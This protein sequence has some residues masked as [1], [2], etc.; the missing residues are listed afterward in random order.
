M[1]RQLT[2]F[3]T[4][5]R[6]HRNIF[7]GKY[8]FTDMSRN[9]TE[10]KKIK[11]ISPRACLFFS[12]FQRKREKHLTRLDNERDTHTEN[13]QDWEETDKTLWKKRWYNQSCR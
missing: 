7:G 11:L 4:N 13:E 6:P 1:G 12:F 9:E 10:N 2:A 5:P 8:N 3:A